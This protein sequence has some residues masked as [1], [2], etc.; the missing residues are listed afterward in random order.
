MR[1]VDIP[2]FE[3]LNTTLAVNVFDFSAEKDNDYKLVPLFFSKHNE[4]RRIIDLILY[5]N[6]YIIL[7][8]LLVFFGKHDNGYICRNCLSIYTIQSELTT[9]KRI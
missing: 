5:T 2:I 9:H 1:N 8:K 6:L 7:E 4:N 3:T